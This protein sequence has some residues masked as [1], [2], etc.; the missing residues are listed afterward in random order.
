[1]RESQEECDRARYNKE[2]QEWE[3]RLI[4]D[5]SSLINIEVGIGITAGVG[6]SGAISVAIGHVLPSFT[7]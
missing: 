7:D 2:N 3:S 1:M 4:Y 5:K 6:I